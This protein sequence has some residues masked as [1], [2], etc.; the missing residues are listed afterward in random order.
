MLPFRRRLWPVLAVYVGAPVC[1]EYLQAYLSA[2]GKAFELLAGLLFLGPLYGGATLLIREV[3]VRTGRGWRGVLL[4]A[5]A[6]G[7]AM[8]GLIDLSLFGAHNAELPYWEQLRGPTLIET[9][10]FALQPALGW[11]AGHVLMSVGAPLALLHGLA[12]GQRARPLL[13]RPGLAVVAVLAI[14]AAILIHIDGRHTYGYVPGPAQ[15]AGVSLVV[16]ALIAIA[17]TRWGRPLPPSRPVLHEQAPTVASAVVLLGG[18]VGKPAIDLMPNTWVGAAGIAAIPIAGFVAI[19]WL[20][21]SYRWGPREIGLL[22]AAAVIGG[23]L[24]GFLTPIPEG[25][26]AAS[27]YA[28]NTIMLLCAVG[29]TV[30]V[31]RATQANSAQPAGTDAPY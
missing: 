22:G 19:Y 31:Y 4:L 26:T 6:F 30:L 27:K 25:V 24:T 20:A 9:L 5:A 10:G 17:F 15:V 29:L 21:R 14:I 11:I 1:A 7:V 18:L 2:T 13:G 28:Q 8:P 16:L 23:T 3:A 12:P